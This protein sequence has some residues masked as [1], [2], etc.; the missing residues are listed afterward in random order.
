MALTAEQALAIQA[1]RGLTV[2]PHG[3]DWITRQRDGARVRVAPQPTQV[4]A[5]E[6]ADAELTAREAVVAERRAKRIVQEQQRGLLYHK[7]RVELA[8]DPD[9]GESA[10]RTVFDILKADGT[11]TATTGRGSV[12]EAWTDA[13]RTTTGNGGSETRSNG[14]G[15]APR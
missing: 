13:I 14:N 3:D 9:T 7:P 12:I 8:V 5:I 11:A 10:D 2:E 1:A 6:V 4:A 15:G